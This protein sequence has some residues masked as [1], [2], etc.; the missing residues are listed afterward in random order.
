M[1]RSAL[2]ASLLLTASF[3][4]ASAHGLRFAVPEIIQQHKV[5]TGLVL[6]ATAFALYSKKFGC[7]FAKIPCLANLF[8]GKNTQSKSE[9]EKRLAALEQENK[10]SFYY[11]KILAEALANA[12]I[13]A[14]NESEY[15]LEQLMQKVYP[16]LNQKN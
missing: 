13:T 15:S 14:D 11:I 2:L 5:A 7:P 12:N 16:G 9:L 8:S 4:P 3:A 1:N 10:K 6:G